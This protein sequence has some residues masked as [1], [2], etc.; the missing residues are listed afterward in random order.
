LIL[1][2][3]YTP[4]QRR[5]QQIY[6]RSCL[7]LSRRHVPESQDTDTGDRELLTL[8]PRA[9]SSLKSNRIK[10]FYRLTSTGGWP[11]PSW[12]VPTQGSTVRL[13]RGASCFAPLLTWERCTVCLR[14]HDGR[15]SNVVSFYPVKAVNDGMVICICYKIH[16]YNVQSCSQW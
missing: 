1:H 12:S 15:V 7:S 5:H 13:P 6:S 16:N 4:S 2:Q 8:H 9:D 11:S 14:P 3:K 10:K